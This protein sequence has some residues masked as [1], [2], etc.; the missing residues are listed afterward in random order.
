MLELE[1]VLEIKKT[2]YQE[3]ILSEDIYTHRLIIPGRAFSPFVLFADIYLLSYTIQRLTLCVCAYACDVHLYCL[4]AKENRFS[5]A[6]T[7]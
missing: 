2:E 6:T 4:A 1:M 7:N 5:T 3:E